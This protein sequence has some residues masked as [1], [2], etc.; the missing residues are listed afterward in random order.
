VQ[1]RHAR[2]KVCHKFAS[3]KG[4]GIHY[5]QKERILF[6]GTSFTQ[7]VKLN[8]RSLCGFNR[9]KQHNNDCVSRR[10]VADEA[11]KLDLFHP[12][13]EGTDVGALDNP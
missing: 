9:W 1:S 10:S 4:S 2:A 6:N 7:P 11:K 12:N 3:L 5:T 8:V 13:A